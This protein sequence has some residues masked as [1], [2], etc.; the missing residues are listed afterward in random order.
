MLILHRRQQTI[1]CQGLL[2]VCVC[3]MMPAPR[4]FLA[5]LAKLMSYSTKLSVLEA[6]HQ[7]EESIDL[8][9][10]SKRCEEPEVMKCSF[11]YKENV[12]V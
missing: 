11:R 5:A 4:L 10:K 7:L 6:Q 3:R 2:M 1:S 8:T 9:E 12:R